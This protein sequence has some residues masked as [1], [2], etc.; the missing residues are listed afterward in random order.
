MSDWL[1]ECISESCDDFTPLGR[2]DKEDGFYSESFFCINAFLHLLV[3]K[4]LFSLPVLV[5]LLVLI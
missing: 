4:L 2:R 5:L 1:D 3:Q